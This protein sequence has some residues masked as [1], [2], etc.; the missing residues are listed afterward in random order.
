MAQL[1][2]RQAFDLALQHHQAGRLPQAEQFY[3]QIL[4]EQPEH[5][6]ALH[7]LGVIAHQAGRNDIAMDLIRRALSIRP[8]N[9]EAYSNLGNLLKEQGQFD[10]A[11]DAYRRAIVLKPD[12]A[13]AHNN[14][15]AV[16]TNQ[17][18]LDQ[19][20]TAYQQAII[21]NPG[22]VEAHSNLG[23]SLRKK[24]NLDE[25][26]AE[27][28]QAIA[29]NPNYAAAHSN[30]GNA[31]KEKGC[32]NEAIAAYQQAIALKP[33]L[34]EAHYNLA[35][36]LR[37]IGQFDQ[38]I[39]AGRRAALLMPKS[40]E[41]HSKLGGILK[42]KGLIDEAITAYRQAIALNAR[43]AEAHSDLGNALSDKKQFDEAVVAYRLSIAL[44]PD[45]PEVYNNLGNALTN[46][47]L[48][49]EAIIAF[50]QAIALR[51]GMSE[52][53]ANLGTALKGE[54]RL[55]DAIAA[56][57]QALAVNPNYTEAHSLL[58]FTLHL[59]PSYDA[60]AIAEELRRW[61]QKH[62]EPLRK[63]V[64]GHSN[65]RS[66]DRRLRVGYISPDFRE[67]VV[68]QNLLPLFQ[69]HDR[70]QFDIACYAHVLSPDAITSRFQ[71]HADRWR[72]IVGCADE[73]VA[74]QIREDRIDILVDLSLHTG[75]NRLLVFARKPA[76]VQV[77]YMAYCS[78]SGMGPIDYRLSDPHIDPPDTDLSC[79]SEKT[80]RL[81]RTYWCYQPAGPADEP[82]ASPVLKNRF[83]TF[84][85][86]NG[87]AKVSTPALDLWTK[88]LL[89]VPNSRMILHAPPGTHIEETAQRL[90]DAGVAK[91]RLTFVPWQT[92]T[93]YTGT[94]SQIDIALD[95]FPYAGGITTCAMLWMG[96]PVVT[97]SGKTAVGRGGRSILSNIGLTELIA[98]MPDQYAKIAI[99]LAQDWRRLDDLRQGMRARMGA[100][101]LMD[102]EQ[103]ARDVETAYRRMWRNW[104]ETAR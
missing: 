93:Q 75:N 102:A 53:H 32:L 85:C 86:L 76:P 7:Y 12:Y 2:I 22:Y 92:W 44:R 19:A 13:A 14:L 97:L 99:E 83:I 20:I 56:Y 89:A 18:Q 49:D 104:C 50:R 43:Y 33:D 98:F 40:P 39:V 46:M 79:H 28:H 64:Q 59:H 82:S 73:K 55:D 8:D 37:D 24:G 6:D 52:A 67:N 65:D 31:L 11:V 42:D 62:A 10:A 41:V 78:S 51:P 36:A 101:P 34:P 4:A 74:T 45:L 60:Q 38:A 3:R 103:F 81:P 94:C 71:Q 5:A 21:L 70:R 84:G 58:I 57:R 77:T 23:N 35:N 80:V 66:P 47:G 61:S 26:I 17:G 27:Y 30:L 72:N 25:A 88:I 54:G 100:S 15:G 16:L 29:L 96:V 1:T 48:L 68:G 90:H 95:P 9:A 69:H 63:F 91:S 87:F